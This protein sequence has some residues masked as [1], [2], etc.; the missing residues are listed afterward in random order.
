VLSQPNFI[1]MIVLI[2]LLV[3]DVDVS[4]FNHIFVLYV[5]WVGGYQQST[6]AGVLPQSTFPLP[7]A[8]HQRARYPPLVLWIQF[9]S[10]SSRFFHSAANNL[11]SLLLL[12]RYF[13]HH[14]K[15]GYYRHIQQHR[16]AISIEQTYNS[17]FRIITS[18]SL[19]VSTSNISNN[20]P[21]ST[22]APSVSYCIVCNDDDEDV[23]YKCK[24]NGG[25]CTYQLCAGCVKASFNDMSGAHSSFCAL[26]KHPSAL[27]MISA[28]CG[29][30]AINAV[31]EKFR[32]KVE[33]QVK[34]LLMKRE[35]SR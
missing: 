4:R 10:K 26:C 17:T 8:R 32:N 20:P 9:T 19:P 7:C 22:M 15:R 35:A 33:F 3:G 30:G 34:E 11:I 28:V 2:K 16:Q 18:I 14:P 27:D 31:E 13:L 1:E 12:V 6:S 29:R 25:A 23:V 24:G 5:N 21:L